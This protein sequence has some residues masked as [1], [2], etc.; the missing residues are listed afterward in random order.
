MLQTASEERVTAG[1]E[2]SRTEEE[3]KWYGET[4]ARPVVVLAGDPIEG[5]EELHAQIE[6]SG[7]NSVRL[8]DLR[9]RKDVP[10]RKPDV[11]VANIERIHVGIARTW[12][13]LRQIYEG[14]VVGIVPHP[15]EAE[16]PMLAGISADMLMFKPL[17]LDELLSQLRLLIWKKRIEY[18][19]PIF[20]RRRYDRRKTGRTYTLSQE[21]GKASWL[22][23]KEG[24]KLVVRGTRTVRL[25]PKE[26]QLL[27]LL[28]SAPGCVF[29]KDE[30]LAGVWPHSKRAARAD[31][32]QY[33]CSLRKK[34][35][36][37]PS[38]PMI[39]KTVAAFGYKLDYQYSEDG[40]IAC[41]SFS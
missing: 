24:A 11:I 2:V 37:D 4:S 41:Q 12:Q 31:V 21:P 36:E 27:S 8:D 30:I 35:E 14:P 32:Q 23:I 40:Y 15:Q 13:E 9:H 38:K 1:C 16:V 29:S 5:I 10:L 34:L 25:T 18:T 6:R 28:A 19:H 39:I 26:F 3:L 22:Q 7:F 20:D 17:R 33:I